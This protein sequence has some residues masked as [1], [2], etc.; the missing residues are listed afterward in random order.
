MAIAAIVVGFLVS[1]I[2]GPSLLH[3]R[4]TTQVEHLQQSEEVQHSQLPPEQQ[5]P[6][7]PMQGVDKA[8]KS[9]SVMKE[10]SAS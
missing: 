9:A 3:H 7:A 6:L 10:S 1:I 4:S 8:P 5:S 2:G